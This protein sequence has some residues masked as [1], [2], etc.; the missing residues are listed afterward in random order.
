MTP[1]ERLKEIESNYIPTASEV[2]VRWLIARVRLLTNAVE[3][4]RADC[5]DK[6]KGLSARYNSR[7]CLFKT[8]DG[9]E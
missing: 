3:K 1:A 9:D 4:Y 7:K 2:E 5:F 8:L 6:N